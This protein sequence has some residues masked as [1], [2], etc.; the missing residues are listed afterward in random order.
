[1]ERLQQWTKENND[2]IHKEAK[3]LADILANTI[4]VIYTTTKYAPVAL[5]MR[6]QLNENSRML[7][8][9]HLIPEHNHNEL[10]GL[11]EPNDKV[12]IIFYED[13]HEYKRNTKRYELTR[14]VLD[15]RGYAHHTYNMH[16][17]TYLQKVCSS[18]Y[19]I[20]RCSY[21][22]AMNRGV[23]PSGMELIEWL[24]GELKA[25]V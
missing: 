14:K 11:Q 18:M 12:T 19:R 15:E 9:D 21:Y 16:G 1:L 6:Q 23:D 10:L 25:F 8:W 5:R 20:D 7:C 22:T 24:K 17:E 2:R 3:D 13:V 4:P